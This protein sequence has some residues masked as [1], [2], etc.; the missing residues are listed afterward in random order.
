MAV[1]EVICTEC[2]SQKVVKYGKAQ[3][4][5]QRYRCRAMDCGKTFQLAHRYIACEHGVKDRIVDMALNG[6]GI[7]D[8]ARVLSVAV[9][10]VITTI[11]KSLQPC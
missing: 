11:K 4:G 7:R 6:S 3:T 8:T 9:G 2:G 5:A 1:V 10:R